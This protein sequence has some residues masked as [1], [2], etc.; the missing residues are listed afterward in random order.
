MVDFGYRTVELRFPEITHPS[1]QVLCKFEQSVFHGDA[2]AP[3]GQFLDALFE[4]HEG[5]VRP[6][7]FGA[8]E[9]KTEKGDLVGMSHLALLLVDFELE[10]L[11]QE[12]SDASH[13]P[14][15][16]PTTFH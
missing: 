7:D 15:T 9:G 16:C 10:F 11:F 13:Y 1:A 4:A 12:T 3:S 5:F 2:P 8:R 6:A 14:L